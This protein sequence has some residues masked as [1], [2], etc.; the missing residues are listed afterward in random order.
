MSADEEKP[1]IKNEE[2]QNRTTPDTSKKCKRSTKKKQGKYSNSEK[3]SDEGSDM[4]P[5]I[6]AP[7]ESPNDRRLYIVSYVLQNYGDYASDVT[8]MINIG[9]DIS[10]TF[11]QDLTEDEQM[12]FSKVHA[13]Q[14]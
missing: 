14:E 12:L 6:I 13:F 4:L 3:I 2:G 9:G 7:T 5:H 8:T 11:P 1:G 10:I